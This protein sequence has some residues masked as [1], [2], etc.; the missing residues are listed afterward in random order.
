[1]AIRKCHICGK[2]FLLAPCNLYKARVNG[3]V[4]QFCSY[5]CFRE[6]QKEKEA[7]KAHKEG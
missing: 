7:K 4:K 3:R 1:M 5:H 6:L 2:E